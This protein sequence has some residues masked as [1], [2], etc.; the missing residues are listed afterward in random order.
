MLIV[1]EYVEYKGRLEY[2]GRIS[3]EIGTDTN[4]RLI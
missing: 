2:Q 1:L 3:N 4:K